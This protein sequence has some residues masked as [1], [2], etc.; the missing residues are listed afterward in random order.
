MR[1]EIIWLNRQK[2]GCECLQ[3]LLTLALKQIKGYE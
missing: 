3:A 1:L 2:V